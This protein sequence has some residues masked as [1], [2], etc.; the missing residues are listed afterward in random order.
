MALEDP[1]D[2]VRWLLAPRNQ[3]ELEVLEVLAQGEF[4][5]PDLQGRL[6]L[7]HPQKL[8]RSLEYLQDRGLVSQFRDLSGKRRGATYKIS[9]IGSRVLAAVHDVQELL[10]EGRAEV[11]REVVQSTTSSIRIR[12]GKGRGKGDQRLP[13][14]DQTIRLTE[15]GVAVLEIGS[16]SDGSAKEELV[17]RA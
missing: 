10:S 17:V 4:R 2:V 16:F 13:S 9:P 3:R 11:E 12:V 1:R 7:D 15:A 8:Y 6:D 14:L 5:A